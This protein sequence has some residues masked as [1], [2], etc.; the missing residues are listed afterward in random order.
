VISHGWILGDIL[1]P[2]EEK[3]SKTSS[4]VNRP[5]AIAIARSSDTMGLMEVSI[6]TFMV[7]FNR[8]SFAGKFES[9]Q[10]R[11]FLFDT[12]ENTWKTAPLK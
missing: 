1:S 3:I 10:D 11:K 12:N 6:S 9:Q 4:V 7:R 8:Q 2:F 5:M